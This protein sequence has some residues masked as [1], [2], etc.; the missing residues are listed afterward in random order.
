VR[1]C[2]GFSLL[3]GRGGDAAC[4]ELDD[5]EDEALPFA[6][7]LCSAGQGGGCEIAGA[8]LLGGRLL[9]FERALG[10]TRCDKEKDK[11]AR[12]TSTHASGSRSSWQLA[13]PPE[14]ARARGL[15]LLEKACAGGE[16]VEDACLQLADQREDPDEKAL[17]L[18]ERVCRRGFLSACVPVLHARSDPSIEAHAAGL[19]QKACT[20]PGREP[21]ADAC[22]TLGVL[23]ATGRGAKE[24]ASGAR[25]LYIKACEAQRAAGCSSLVQQT[26]ATGAV[27]GPKERPLFVKAAEVLDASCKMSDLAACRTLGAMLRRGLGV[28]E[29]LARAREVL[30]PL[31]N[32]QHDPV[33]CADLRGLPNARK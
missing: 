2:A 6:L 7:A 19:A 26:L 23:I 4:I 15:D 31:C 28:R 17:A 5:A 13:R 24:D 10:A 21:D 33:A 8:L 29:D 25:A 16:G 22:A 9:G 27:A 20:A 3:R 11:G 12:C 14:A 18:F 30:D 32:E 1:A